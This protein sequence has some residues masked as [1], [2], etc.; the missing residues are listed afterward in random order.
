MKFDGNS[1]AFGAPGII[2]GKEGICTI[3]M[4]NQ[5]GIIYHRFFYKAELIH[6]FKLNGVPFFQ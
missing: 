5:T 2:N 3:M 1:S 6:K 4:N